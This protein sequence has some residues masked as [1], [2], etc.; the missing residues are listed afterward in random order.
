MKY[1]KIG[2]IVDNRYSSYR[3]NYR[4]S[5]VNTNSSV[6]SV[7]LFHYIETFNHKLWRQV[8]LIWVGGK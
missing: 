8:D 4:F 3:L 5:N 1:Y 6:V 2:K 7:V